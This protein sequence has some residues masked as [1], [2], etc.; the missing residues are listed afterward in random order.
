MEVVRSQNAHAKSK[1]NRAHVHHGISCNRRQI[2][3]L[4]L[5][6]EY[7]DDKKREKRCS[8][9]SSD[10]NEAEHCCEGGRRL[11]DFWGL[12][13]S[14][15]GYYGRI[16]KSPGKS[17]SNS[18]GA[19]FFIFYAN[20]TGGLWEEK[21]HRPK[22]LFHSSSPHTHP[23]LQPKTCS[24]VPV[25]PV[26]YISRCSRPHCRL[27][28]SS[29]PPSPPLKSPSLP[30]TSYLASGHPAARSTGVLSQSPWCRLHLCR[31]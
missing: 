4:K 19:N 6:L 31:Y 18:K 26:A 30:S 27:K 5:T 22:S 12:G 8:W 17:A 3:E 13:F 10:G 11:R 21:I 9:T 7:G 2:E 28:L 20:V 29:R 24:A 1:G 14:E 15:E 16:L 25:A 23:L